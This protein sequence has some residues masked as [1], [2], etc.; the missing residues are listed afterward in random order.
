MSP[1]LILILVL[2]VGAAGGSGF[3]YGGHVKESEMIAQQAKVVDKVIADHNESSVIDMQAAFE[4]G[5]ASAKAR[6]SGETLRSAAN[7][8]NTAS[9]FA[10]TCRLNFERHRVLYAAIAN[11]NGDTAN[12]NGLPDAVR[13]ANAPGK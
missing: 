6:S 2:A 13:K 12:P 9:P 7:A 11:A 3:L 8:A 4:A 10:A 5:A 1:T